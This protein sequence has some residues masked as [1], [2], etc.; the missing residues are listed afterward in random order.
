MSMT[1][2]SASSTVELAYRRNPLP[3]IASLSWRLANEWPNRGRWR[4]G[5]SA[6]AV[7]RNARVLIWVRSTEGVGLRAV[8]FTSV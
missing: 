8:R 1:G 7:S 6:A 5:P 2:D 3:S 4:L